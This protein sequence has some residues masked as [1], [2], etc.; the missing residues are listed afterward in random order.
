M[1]ITRQ[2]ILS[3]IL[4]AGV[5]LVFEVTEID[6]IV[7]DRFYPRDAGRW[8][9]DKN[10]PVLRVALYTGP[11][12]VIIAFGVLSLTA[13]AASFRWSR[14]RP[15][16]LPCLRICLSLPAVPLLVAGLKHVSNVHTPESISRYGGHEPYVKLL[17]K[18]PPD[19]QQGSRPEGWPAGHSSGG[20]AMMVLYYAFRSPRRRALGLVLG[21]TVG[22]TMG[23][24]QIAKGAHYLSHTVVTMLLA[25]VVV[26]I[27]QAL[28]ERARGRWR[29]LEDGGASR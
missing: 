7:Q 23:I 13:L 18:Y 3:V 21:L 26:L 10:D 14:L 22:W 16:R 1:S 9:V 15:L 11:K 28:T 24:Y 12:A 2:I 4:L 27:V 6:I 19:L 17:E 5:L 29:A 25:W 20:F 8:V